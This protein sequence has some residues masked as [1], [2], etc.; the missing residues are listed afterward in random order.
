MYQDKLCPLGCGEIDNL[1]NLLTCS[2]LREKHRSR[3]ITHTEIMFQDI[4]SDDVYKQQK[5]TEMFKQLLETR[6]KIMQS[7]PVANDTGPVH[8]SNAVQNLSLL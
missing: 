7:I 4:F 5:V 2:V 8:G 1:E 6:N 3:E